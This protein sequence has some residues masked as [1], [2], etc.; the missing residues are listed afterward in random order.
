MRKES[1]S[2]VRIAHIGH[3][4]HSMIAASF[5]KIDSISR[6]LYTLLI[7]AIH[8]NKWSVRELWSTSVSLA[9]A[10]R[11]QRERVWVVSVHC[12]CDVRRSR[13]P[14]LACWPHR[15]CPKQKRMNSGVFCFLVFH[16]NS[17]KSY[18]LHFAFCAKKQK[19]KNQ[20][21][22]FQSSR[23]FQNNKVHHGK[24]SKF[25]R[26]RISAFVGWWFAQIFNVPKRYF[27]ISRQTARQSNKV[28][29]ACGKIRVIFNCCVRKSYL[30]SI[31]FTLGRLIGQDSHRIV[32]NSYTDTARKPSKRN[33]AWGSDVCEC[34]C[35]CVWVCVSVSGGVS[36]L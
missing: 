19:T 16:K 9:L 1:T 11:D 7:H 18:I 36:T 10:I 3:C 2:T 33:C 15:H 28:E 30:K 20:D 17:Q 21:E 5:A 26:F 6:E 23:E 4:N 31:C 27:D 34:V 24:T 35:E 29:E 25:W 8:T 22:D 12:D 13:L 32:K 14:L